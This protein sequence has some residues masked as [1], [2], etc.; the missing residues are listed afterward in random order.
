[1]GQYY[2]TPAKPR[3]SFYFIGDSIT[4]KGSLLETCG[5]IALMQEHYVRSVDMINRGLGGWNTRCV[6]CEAH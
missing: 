3:P 5:W 4:Q 6:F 1:M 2:A